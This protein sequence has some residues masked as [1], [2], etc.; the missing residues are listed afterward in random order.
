[1]NE[2]IDDRGRR[3]FVSSQCGV[4]PPVFGTCFG[5]PSLKLRHKSKNLPPRDTREEAQS[6]LDAHAAKMGWREIEPI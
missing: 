3:L 5:K 4:H 6:D 1:M 2:Y